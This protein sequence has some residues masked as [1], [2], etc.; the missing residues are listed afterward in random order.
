MRRR[1]GA[2]AAPVAISQRRPRIL[3]AGAPGLLAPLRQW[4]QRE[5]LH[6]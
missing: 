5:F 6:C 3:P 1:S 4:P 2:I